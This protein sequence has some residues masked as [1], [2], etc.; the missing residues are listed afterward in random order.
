MKKFGLES[1][2]S[3]RTPMSPNIKLIVD[4]LGKSVDPSLYRSM[5][6]SFLYLTASRPNISYSV[7]VWECVLDIKLIPKNLI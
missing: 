2:N 4:L 3:V 1:A 5:I 7:G 6:G